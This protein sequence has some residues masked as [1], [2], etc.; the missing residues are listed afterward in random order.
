[1]VEPFLLPTHDLANSVGRFFEAA[2]HLSNAV[3]NLVHVH[4]AA[5]DKA[6]NQFLS[7]TWGS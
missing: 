3:G 4:D 1:V 7:L 2:L 6:P 5:N